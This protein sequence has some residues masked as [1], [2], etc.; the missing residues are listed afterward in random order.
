MNNFDHLVS[1]IGSLHD[2]MRR[3]AVGSVNKMLTFRNW[4][5]G[6]YI[7]EYEQKGRDRAEYGANLIPRLAQ[8]LSGRRGFSFRNLNLFREFYLVYP[9]ISQSVSA[10][11]PVLGIGSEILQLPTT[12][13]QPNKNKEVMSI[14]PKAEQLVRH[15]SFTHFVELIRIADPLKR[16]FYEIEGI[17]GCWSVPQLKRQIESQLYEHVPHVRGDEPD[18][19]GREEWFSCSWILRQYLR[20]NR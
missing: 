20:M 17:K 11:L 14:S 7:V 19:Q 15:F 16:A 8:R 1:S 2:S 10:E 6:R 18:K 9:Q 5:I 13:L 3:A 4:L 12:Q